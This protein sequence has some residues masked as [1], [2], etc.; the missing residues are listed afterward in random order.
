MPEGKRIYLLSLGC[1]KNLVDSEAL[2]RRLRALGHTDVE[3]PGEADTLMV[4]TCGFIEEAKRESI[5][6]ILRLGALKE[7]GQR[8]LV[9]G[10]LSE[11]Y[12]EELRRELPEVDALWGVD[13]ARKI[14]EYLGGGEPEEKRVSVKPSTYPYAYLK[15][16]EGCRRRCSF[17]T[18]PS[19]RGPLRN[20][21]PEEILGEARALLAFGIKELILVA[22]DTTAYNVKGYALGELLRDLASIEGDFRLRVHYLH[23]QGI[24]EGLLEA[25]AREDKVVKYMDMPLQHSGER[26]LRLMGRGGTAKEFKKLIFRIRRDIPGVALRTT[27]MVG[28]PGESEEEFQGLLDFA[29]E[30]GFEHM[31]AFVY[32]KE[33]GTRAASLKGHLPKALKERR[34]EELMRAQAAVSLEKNRALLGRSFRVLIDGPPEAGVAIGR[35][36]TQSPEV[37]GVV[38]VEGEGLKAGDFVQVRVTEAY[39][40]DLRGKPVPRDEMR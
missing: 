21:P 32:S 19:I 10:C 37:D 9:L 36:P 23:P 40:Y 30:Q 16:A 34:L 20:F 8:L 28:F 14:A 33:E 7:S 17:C 31:G 1:P 13:A 18:I 35:L 4:N 25:I 22:Q 3:T 38:F 5:E 2:L 6:E 27:F 11:R 12:G 29:E 15:I 24:D 26:I 39:D